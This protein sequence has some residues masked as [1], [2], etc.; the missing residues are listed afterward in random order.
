[1]KKVVLNNCYGGF[2]L[3]EVGATEIL[4]R[5]GSSEDWHR[6]AYGIERHD[7]DLIAVLEE[8][9]AAVVGDDYSELVIEEYDEENF[10]YEINE[11]DGWESLELIPVVSEKRVAACGSTKEI[12]DYLESLGINVVRA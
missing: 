12:M 4:K 7:T 1:M 8:L 10:T 11:Y 3:S 6:L 2:G 9:G 5:K